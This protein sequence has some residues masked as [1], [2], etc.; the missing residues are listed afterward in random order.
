MKHRE[1]SFEITSTVF[2]LVFYIDVTREMT[3]IVVAKTKNQKPA[4]VFVGN[5]SRNRKQRPQMTLPFH[6]KPKKA[7]RKRGLSRFGIRF[8]LKI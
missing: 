3:P 5:Y 6:H 1:R 2:K 8:Y 4:D 7:M